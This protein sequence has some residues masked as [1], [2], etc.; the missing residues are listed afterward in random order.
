MV[1][2]LALEADV[3]LS[4]Q[5]LS[6]NCLTKLYIPCQYSCPDKYV[7]MKFITFCECVCGIKWCQNISNKSCRYE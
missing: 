6:A 3:S 4:T 1:N 2:V 7:S 5:S